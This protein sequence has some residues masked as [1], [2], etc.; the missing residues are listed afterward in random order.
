MPTSIAERYAENPLHNL[1]EQ[2][3]DVTKEAMV[4]FMGCRDHRATMRKITIR[5]F[6]IT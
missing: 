1:R 6:A 3:V 2:I 5:M 4:G